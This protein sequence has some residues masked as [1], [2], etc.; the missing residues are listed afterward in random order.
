MR[1]ASQKFKTNIFVKILGITKIPLMFFC[2]PKVMHIDSDSVIIK[3]PST[4]S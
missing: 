1:F 3:I 2:R 4:T